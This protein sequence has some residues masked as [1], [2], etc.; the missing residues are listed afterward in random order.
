MKNS[1]KVLMFLLIALTIAFII[2][3]TN[4][5]APKKHYDITLSKVDYAFPSFNVTLHSNEDVKEP[6][7]RVEVWYEQRKVANL[8]FTSIQFN[9]GDSFTLCMTLDTSLP[10]NETLGLILLSNASE[11]ARISFQTP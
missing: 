11:I 8:E 3:Y 2:V 10:S 5:F 6:I 7:N 9:E 4:P 1:H